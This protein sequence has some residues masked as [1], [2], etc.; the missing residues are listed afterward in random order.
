MCIKAMIERI[1]GGF[2][3]SAKVVDGTLILSLPDAVDPVVWRMDLGHVRSSAIEVRGQ[4]DGTYMLTLKTPKSDVNDIAPYT[5]RARAVAALVAVSRAMEQGRGE[6][7]PAAATAA[8]DSAP[9]GTGAGKTHD[10]NGFTAGRFLAGI[11]GLA[12]VAGLIVLMM[13]IAPAPAQL[14][15]A[16]GGE[17]S[18]LSD[19]AAPINNDAPPGEPVSADDFLR[20]R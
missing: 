12:I 14:S 13:R 2:S 10:D 19:S 4:D 11:F 7:R 16:S 6:I 3:A 9:G 20:A 15:P 18:A 17:M 8:N 1:T 5:S